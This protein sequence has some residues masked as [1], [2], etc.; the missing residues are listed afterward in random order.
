[1]IVPQSSAAQNGKSFPHDLA[2][3]VP[4]KPGVVEQASPAAPSAGLERPVCAHLGLYDDQKTWLAFPSPGNHCHHVQPA[5]SVD[6]VHQ[7]THCLNSNHV[8]CPVWQVQKQARRLPPPLQYAPPGRFNRTP[9]LTVLILLVISLAVVDGLLLWTQ[10]RGSGDGNPMQAPQPS[11]ATAL[12]T[13]AAA[14]AVPTQAPTIAAAVITKREMPTATAEIPATP[15]ATLPPPQAVVTGA[16]VKLHSGPSSDY[17][18]LLTAEQGTQY[19][20]TGRDA[21]G[22]WWRVCCILDGAA[23]WVPAAAIA[24]S[25]NTSQTPAIDDIPALEAP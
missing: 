20:I 25:G 15:A 23:G 17:A 21:S 10:L 14:A 2:P 6:L 3:A 7:Q 22:D 5:G 18:V 13:V 19:E 12:P 24:I 16:L 8:T 4:E 1:M 9:L 11:I